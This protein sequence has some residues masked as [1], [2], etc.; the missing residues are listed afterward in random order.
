MTATLFALGTTP[1]VGLFFMLRSHTT[2]QKTIVA[3]LTLA[4]M[5]LE[6]YTLPKVQYASPQESV[7]PFSNCH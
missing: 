6:I 3:V 1:W 2:R 5:L 4:T 7:R